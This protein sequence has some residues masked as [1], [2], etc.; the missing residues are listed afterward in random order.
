MNTDQYSS[1]FVALRPQFK[2]R[3]IQTG[4]RFTLSNWLHAADVLQE[5]VIS[6]IS[7]WRKPQRHMFLW[8]MFGAQC[9]FVA[10]RNMSAQCPRTT[11]HVALT[12][13]FGVDSRLQ[14]VKHSA[15]ALDWVLIP[16]ST[17]AY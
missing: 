13:N 2:F 6:L 11:R 15:S 9:G 10:L 8:H 16:Q 14:A 4:H 3:G 7:A 5:P 12:K 1:G 17:R